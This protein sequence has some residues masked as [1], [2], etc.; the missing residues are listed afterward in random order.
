MTILDPLPESSGRYE[1]NAPFLHHPADGEES[2]RAVLPADAPSVSVIIPVKNEAANLPWVFARL[3]EG[4]TEV[5]V[6]DGHSTD[7]TVAVAKRL[8]PDAVVVT[9][10]RRG[11]GNAMAC[12]FAVAT[13]E[14]LVMLDADGSAHPGE[15]VDFVEALTAGA[16]FA[17]GSRFIAGGGSSDITGIRRWG[18]AALSGLVNLLYKTRFSDLCY[19]YNAF[20]A[21]C[22]PYFEL[23]STHGSEPKQGDGFE[24]ETLINVRAAQS[25]LSIAE[26]ASF[27]SCR[28]HGSSNLNAV[29][30]GLRI[31]RVIVREWRDARRTE[32]PQTSSMP[33]LAQ[34]IPAP[35]YPDDDYLAPLSRELADTEDVA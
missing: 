35:A 19:G 29:R 22:L 10:T 32:R 28:L 24:I 5:V 7:D 27:E 12:G 25:P 21:H 17:K 8:R 13:G 30:D 31:L 23:P 33:A 16:D 1:L 3:P 11:K 9:Q 4:V 26:V 6:V 14:I 2:A 18:N 15:I 20:W 34:L